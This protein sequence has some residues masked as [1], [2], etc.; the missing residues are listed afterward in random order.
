[1]LATQPRTCGLFSVSVQQV[2]LAPT[3]HAGS[4]LPASALSRRRRAFSTRVFSRCYMSL[5]TSGLGLD[6]FPQTVLPSLRQSLIACSKSPND[7]VLPEK[8][9]N[10][11]ETTQIVESSP[12]ISK[13]HFIMTDSSSGFPRRTSAACRICAF[14]RYFAAGQVRATIWRCPIIDA[15]QMNCVPRPEPR[16][17]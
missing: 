9:R 4:I 17:W 1:M 3:V 12:Y 16:T 5:T 2:H 8:I 10:L 14:P 7:H 13:C 15:V 11:L 6:Y